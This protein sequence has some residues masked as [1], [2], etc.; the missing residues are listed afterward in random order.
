MRGRGRLVA[1]RN[2]RKMSKSERKQRAE[3]CSKGERETRTGRVREA[4]EKL[5]IDQLE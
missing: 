4:K 2:V 1:H 5:W 3:G